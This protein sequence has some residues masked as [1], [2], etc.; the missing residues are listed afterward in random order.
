MSRVSTLPPLSAVMPATFSST[1]TH[2]IRRHRSGS[3]RPT[4]CTRPG[5]T[6]RVWVWTRPNR[7]RRPSGESAIV[8]L[9]YFMNSVAT[10]RMGR[11]PVMNA[12]A[13]PP[14]PSVATVAKTMSAVV[15][16]S[17]AVLERSTSDRASCP[18]DTVAMTSSGASPAS[19]RSPAARA[20]TCVRTARASASGRYRSWMLEPLVPATS[21]ETAAIANRRATSG[22]TTSTDCS[23]ESWSRRCC[24]FTM[25]ESIRKSPS[26]SNQ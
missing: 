18:G 23:R 4:A 6:V 20:S 9:K 16:S 22:C 15:A 26:S 5:G 3:I 12:R 2:P 13:R 14:Q 25:P 21:S 10:M 1:R 11:P 8:K 19:C 7:S 24:L 17:P